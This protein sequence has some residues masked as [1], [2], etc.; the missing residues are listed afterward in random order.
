[1]KFCAAFTSMLFLGLSTWAQRAPVDKH[2]LA[3]GLLNGP[4]IV[5]NEE[6]STSLS[7]LHLDHQRNF[8]SFFSLQTGLNLNYLF[9]AKRTERYQYQLNDFAAKDHT[10]FETSH[11]HLILTLMPTFYYRDE[12][13]NLFIG[14]A[15]GF[16]SYW[17]FLTYTDYIVNYPTQG[18]SIYRENKLQ[19]RYLSFGYSPKAG[20]GFNLG[21]KR[22]G[23]EIEIALSY[24][25]WFGRDG[26]N[27]DR[28]YT[29]FGIQ[30]AYRYNFRK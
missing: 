8:T 23:G 15:G 10:A 27:Y 19:D 22:Q 7:G 16:G 1:M 30:T 25:K 9:P 4:A 6:L 11:M 2:G 20:I 12:N 28:G 14:L 29:A 5:T 24:G 18:E 26:F 17:R 21:G 3:I 13:F